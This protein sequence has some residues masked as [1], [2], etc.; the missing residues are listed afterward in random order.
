MIATR[1]D[2]SFACV[3]L[4]YFERRSIFPE[5][6]SHEFGPEDEALNRTAT[7]MILLSALKHVDESLAL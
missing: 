1:V 2:V 6:T 5:L 7:K 4:F 3:F